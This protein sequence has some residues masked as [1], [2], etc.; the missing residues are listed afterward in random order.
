MAQRLAFLSDTDVDR[1]IDAAF[2]VLDKVGIH[3]GDDRT[4]KHVGDHDGATVA[5]GRVTMRRSLVERCLRTAPAAITVYGQDDREPLRLTGE[6]VHYL[7][8][9]SVPYVYDTR[10]RGCRQAV[11]K[12]MVDLIKVGNR[13]DHIDF[14]SGS[15][16]VSDVAKPVAAAYRSFL[17]LLF[18]PKPLF[19]S[20]FGTDDIA[21]IHELLSAVAG[22]R[23]ALE[24]RPLA[25]IGINPTSPLGL[26]E[27]VAINLA[28][29]A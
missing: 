11:T 24:R 22:G 4:L 13:C 15:L 5:N 16:V 19:T 14:V 12:D 7:P 2:A 29:C 18:S 9:S 23:E 21:V 26:T 6:N 10:V 27:V 28:Y 20:A 8:D 1:I 25:V 3:I 17:C